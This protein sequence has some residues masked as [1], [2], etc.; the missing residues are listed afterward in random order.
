MAFIRTTLLLSLLT[1]IFLGAGF[2]IAGAE[3]AIIALVFAVFMNFFSYWYSDKIVLKMHKAIP[4]KNAELEETVHKLAKKAKI[5]NPKLYLMKNGVP[6]AFA[7][8]RNDKHAAVVVST[9]LLNNLD[10]EEI[11]GVLAHELSHIKN[12]DILISSMAATIGGAISFLANMAW[13]NM[14]LGGDQD[15]NILMSLPMLILAPISATIVQ[16]SISRTRE[17]G[18]DNSAGVLT[19]NPKGLANA[20][21]KLE[22]FASANPVKGNAATAH[23]FI[24]NP[25]KTD[26]MSKLFSTHPSTKERI[27][28]L[29][30][31]EK[32]LNL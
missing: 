29:E 18:A 30:E 21:R 2:L 4:L 1:G 27:Q 5:A 13:W 8:G 22:N 6:N 17:Y 3:G 20:L 26:A 28:K 32:K 31:L 7:T 14:F 10:K 16:L 9:G 12:H 24:I 25:F 19:K 11:E 23:L 15:N